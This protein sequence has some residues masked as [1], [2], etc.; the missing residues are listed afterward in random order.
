MTEWKIGSDVI[1]QHDYNR[2][3]IPLKFVA[4]D[5]KRLGNEIIFPS[6]IG[7]FKAERI[8]IKDL[9]AI[10]QYA[11]DFVL[12]HKTVTSPNTVYVPESASAVLYKF[13][14]LAKKDPKS[15]V[16]ITREVSYR[17]PEKIN[18]MVDVMEAVL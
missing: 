1:R 8:P 5:Y 16:I 15:A 6:M 7:F 17:E 14:W 10:I 11:K 18:A 4:I 3:K 13:L 12:Y 9:D 2:Q